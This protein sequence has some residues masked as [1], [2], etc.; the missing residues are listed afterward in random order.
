MRAPVNRPELF[1][2]ETEIAPQRPI[3]LHSDNL[4]SAS[5]PLINEPQKAKLKIC[6]PAK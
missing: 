4:L 2:I 6:L 3:M 5:R 1:Q